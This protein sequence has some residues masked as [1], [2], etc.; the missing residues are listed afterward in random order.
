[1]KD[2]SPGDHSRGCLQGIIVVANGDSGDNEEAGSSGV[3]R[4]GTTVGSSK[5]QA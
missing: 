4:I 3:A 5:H 1:M 2:M